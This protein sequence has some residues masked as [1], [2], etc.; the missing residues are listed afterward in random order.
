MTCVARLEG[1]T[2]FRCEFVPDLGGSRLDF[3]PGVLLW[4]AH[5]LALLDLDG[6]AV[7]ERWRRADD[8]L[9][10]G[11]LIRFPSHLARIAPYDGK[12]RSV[13]RLDRD[14]LA[15]DLLGLPSPE[16]RR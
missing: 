15:G 13:V 7:D 9:E 12:R 6:R 5:R 11:Q 16:Q 1:N 10:A 14:E 3:R 2:R 4:R 8:D